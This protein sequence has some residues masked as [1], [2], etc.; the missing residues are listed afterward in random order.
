MRRLSH[1]SRSFSSFCVCC[2]SCLFLL[3]NLGVIGH[4]A[5]DLLRPGPRD[6]PGSLRHPGPQH[7]RV[8]QRDLAVCS[9]GGTCHAISNVVPSRVLYKILNCIA[10]STGHTCDCIQNDAQPTEQRLLRNNK[11]HR[12]DLYSTLCLY[13]KCRTTHSPEFATK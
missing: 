11:F 5:S 8:G 7:H 9:A 10:Y 1:G 4:V 2:G 3:L 12:C 13:S 6:S